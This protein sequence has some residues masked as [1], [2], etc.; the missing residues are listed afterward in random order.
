MPKIP[1]YE[2]Q[3][4]VSAETSSPLLDRSAEIQ[5]IQQIA[6]T[7][8]KGV[9]N[10]ASGVG[11]MIDNYERLEE[12]SAVADANRE[13]IDFK[14]EV[15]RERDEVLKRD[16]VNLANYEEKYLLPKISEFKQKLNNK[17]YSPKAMRKLVPVIDTDLGDLRNEEQLT[18]IKM[19]L[20]LF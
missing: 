11:D 9:G 4:R 6:N 8:A 20:I 13:M 7:Y 2:Q 5:S 17:G 16:D 19:K 14:L 1:L 18:Q 15:A 10:L 12:Q 3:T